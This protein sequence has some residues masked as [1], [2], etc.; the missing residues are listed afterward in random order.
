MQAYSGKINLVTNSFPNRKGWGKVDNFIFLPVPP[1]GR[2]LPLANVRY[3]LIAAHR[4]GSKPPHL[5]LPISTVSDLRQKALGQPD[6]N[7][8]DL[9]PYTC[10]PLALANLM[11]WFGSSVGA[12]QSQYP[13]GPCASH[14]AAR[15]SGKPHAEPARS[16]I[17]D[18]AR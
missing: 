17:V 14:Q 7:V 6:T 11:H 1:F 10:G 12:R 16:D 8:A 5:R 3:R 2:F 9:L 13:A 15:V 4:N 18:T